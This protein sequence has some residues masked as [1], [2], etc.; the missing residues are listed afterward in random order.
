[1]AVAREENFGPLAPL[2]K[3]KTEEEAI[4]MANNTEFGLAAIST[5]ATSVASGGLRRVW[6]TAWSASMRH[7]LDSRG[8][9]RRCQGVGPGSRGLTP[10]CRGVS[11]NEVHADGRAGTVTRK[12]RES[13]G[14]AALEYIKP[15]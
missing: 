14:L 6:N 10:R 1:M 15:A 4:A 8:A 13:R 5:L 7:H 2:F 9:V 11:G 3:F 12:N